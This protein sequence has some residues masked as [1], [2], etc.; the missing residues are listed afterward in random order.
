[1]RNDDIQ[2]RLG[3]FTLP[4]FRVYVGAKGDISEI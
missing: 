4:V 1:M 3:A 2:D